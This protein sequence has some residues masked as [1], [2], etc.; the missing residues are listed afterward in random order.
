MPQA[1]SDLGDRCHTVKDGKPYY[2]GFTEIE[3]MN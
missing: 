1:V 3:K 2:T